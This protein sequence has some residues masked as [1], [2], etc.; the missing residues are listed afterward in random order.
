MT[1]TSAENPYLGVI[2]SEN[3]KWSTYINKICNKVNSTLGFIRR[4]AFGGI[5]THSPILLPISL[6]NEGRFE[7]VVGPVVF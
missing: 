7:V 5:K 6:V 1:G 4:N 3:L 2:I